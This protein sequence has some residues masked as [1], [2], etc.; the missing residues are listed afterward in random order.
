MATQS[1][2]RETQSFCACPGSNPPAAEITV[3]SGKTPDVLFEEL[4]ARL[5][6]TFYAR[7]DNPA[8]ES[9]RSKL[10]KAEPAEI[11]ATELGG[12]IIREKISKAPGN[13]AA[14]GGIKLSTA[15]GWIAARPSGTEDV[16]KIYAESFVSAEHLARLQADATRI[17]QEL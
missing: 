6:K 7:L 11:S 9:L 8:N 16:Y 2:V 12:D 10:G 13:G 17:L 14:I 15:N 3:R 1:A 4:T 5:G